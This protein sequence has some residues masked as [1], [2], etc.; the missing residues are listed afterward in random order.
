MKTVK[1]DKDMLLKLAAKII[2]DEIKSFSEKKK[3]GRA[4]V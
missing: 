2:A 1:A 3:I 4:H